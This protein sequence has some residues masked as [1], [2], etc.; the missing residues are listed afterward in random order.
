M[1]KRKKIVALTKII[2]EDE[3]ALICDLAETYHILNYKALPPVLVAT[4]IFGLRGNSRIKTKLNGLK[5][6]PE[7]YLLASIVD[8]LTI[9]SHQLAHDKK[10][11]NLLTEKLLADEKGE[12][13]LAFASAEEYEKARADILRGELNG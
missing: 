8:R 2:V 1:Q 4:L 13:V 12:D 3:D 10:K 11:P 6:E 9:I 7:T 5:C